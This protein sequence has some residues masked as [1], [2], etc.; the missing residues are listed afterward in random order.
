MQGDIKYNWI[1]LDEEEHIERSRVLFEDID[2]RRSVRAFSEDP[3]PKE[4][5][6]NAI[7]IASSAPSGAHKQPWTFCL[8]SD[9]EIKRKIRLAA[10]EE[11]KLNYAERMSETWLD[12][13]KKFGTNW[14]KPFLEK[15]PYLIIVFKK[16]YNEKVDGKKQTNYYVN[17]SV[18]LAVGFL[19]MALH[20]IGFHTLTHTPSPMKFL[21]KILN[22]PD[23]ERPFLLIP[24]GY[25]EPQHRVPDLK[26]KSLNEVV[27]EY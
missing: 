19:L 22:R 10:E 1:K 20:Q 18:G 2:K 17:E 4:A 8:V 25:P 27:I 21:S 23:N 13:L 15:A 24:V 14:E 7:R 11:E 16:A 12:D 6:L 26:R 9:K 5:I 3:I